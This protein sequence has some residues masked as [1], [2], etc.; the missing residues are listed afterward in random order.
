M[1]RPVISRRSGIA[2]QVFETLR[3]RI[4]SGRLAPGERII[5]A[6][7]AAEFGVSRTPVRES[8]SRL[9][10]EQLIE[11]LPQFGSFVAPISFEAVNEAQF[12]REHLE[13][14]IIREAARNIDEAG[15]AELRDL[16]DRQRRAAARQDPAEF[17]QLDETMHSSFAEVAGQPGVGRLVRQRKAHLDR[18]RHVSYGQP[19]HLLELVTQHEG[20]VDALEERDAT[21]AEAAL[22]KHLRVVC[23]TIDQLY[24]SIPAAREKRKRRT[25]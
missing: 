13:C 5:E 18:V 11:V 8:L 12:I 25:R 7:L 2:E 4:V 1:V 15:I 24:Q 10:E 23:A 16:L 6:D 19:D 20:V 14:A 3:L 9:A 21:K 17:F 22:R